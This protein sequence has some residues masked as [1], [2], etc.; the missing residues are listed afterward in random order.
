MWSSLE[1]RR[2]PV[3][4]AFVLQYGFCFP[5]TTNEDANKT[6]G[7]A[8][9]FTANLEFPLVST[10][11]LSWRMTKTSFEIS[12]YQGLPAAAIVGPT[13]IYS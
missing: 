13:L 1:N 12:I 9:D 6:F 10:Q 7:T 11:L 5:Q 8:E 2:L 4:Y 3:L